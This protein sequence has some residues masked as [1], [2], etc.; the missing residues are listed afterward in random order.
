MRTASLAGVTI[1]ISLAAFAANAHF[2][3]NVNIRVVHVEH[4][5][6]GVRAYLRLPAPYVLAPRLGPERDDGTRDPAPFTYNRLENGQLMHLI[7]WNALLTAPRELG[8]MV[9]QGHELQANGKAITGSVEQVRVHATSRQPPFATLDEARAVFGTPWL[10]ED[11]RET[12]AGDAVIDVV[13]HYPTGGA[14]Y[15]YRLSSNLDPGLEN[16]EETA[17]L[18]LDHFPGGTQIFRAT[19]LLR[20][21]VEVSRSALAAAWTFIVEGTRHILQG[22]DHVLFVVCLII[23]ATTLGSLLW[24]V[25]GFTIGHSVT[26]ATGFFGWVPSALWFVPAVE[27][28]IAISIIY[29]GVIAL[30]RYEGKSSFIVTAA[31]GLLHGLGFSFILQEILRVDSPNLWQSLLSFNIGIEAGQVCIVFLIWPLLY[32]LDKR[33]APIVVS[34]RWVIALPCI[35]IAAWWTGERAMMV[36]GAM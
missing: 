17:N 27:T 8:E 31:I 20:E 14:V 28:G 29:A 2:Q 30:M 3:L 25:T 10:V 21:P 26:L 34:V 33:K 35:A 36:I 13:I 15:A 11:R 9:M 32:F 23:G 19:G 18:V 16:Q 12:Y 5:S 6:D 24:R 7:D 4:L 22:L 1:I